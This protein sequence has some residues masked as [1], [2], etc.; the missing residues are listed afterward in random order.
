MAKLIN[1]Q[2]L[3]KYQK[4]A[5]VISIVLLA[6]SLGGVIW[7]GGLLYG[8]DFTGGIRLMFEFSRPIE[9]ENMADIR[10]VFQRRLEAARVNTFNLEGEDDSRGLMVTVRGHQLVDDLT[11]ELMQVDGSE[12]FEQ[13]KRQLA[14]QH[15]IT[16]NLLA[17]NFRIGDGAAEKI[18]L[19][20]ADSIDVENRVQR[21]VNETISNQVS[22]LLLRE[23]APDRQGI[24]LNWASE[25][26]IQRWLVDSQVEGFVDEFHYLLEEE[27]ELQELGTLVPLFDQFQIDRAEFESIF[28]VASERRGLLNLNQLELA[29]LAEIM[30]DEFFHGRYGEEAAAIVEARAEKNLFQD[31]SEVLELPALRRLYRP[32][33]E[34]ADGLA[35]FVLI[36]SDMI[37]PAVGADLIRLAMLAVLLSLGGVLAYLYIRFELTYSMAAIAAIFHDVIITVGLLTLLGVEFDVP[38][39]AAVLTV[40]GY[41]LNDTI[42][43][44]DRIREN[45][46]LMGYRADWFKVINRSIYEVL[47]RTLVT[48]ITTFIAVFILYLYGGVA[49][50]A[51]AIT[52]LIGIVAGTYSSIFVSNSVLLKLQLSLR[53]I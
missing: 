23:L 18:N 34:R 2:E 45:K 29:Q 11:R 36:S 9:S 22:T 35:P 30:R 37:S 3:L 41:S 8:I 49:L 43:N 16:E 15:L 47:N 4:H 52:L 25:S 14:E 48:S 13:V 44:F 12:Q 17:E 51:F 46:V 28:T 39:V 32:T 1:W 38:V 26:E 40:I 21:L 33:L 42:V 27:G 20:T 24:D 5:V 6:I 7:Q 10:G 19:E 53:D 50:N 31:L